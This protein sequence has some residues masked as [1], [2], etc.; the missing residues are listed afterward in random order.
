M[1]LISL[2]IKKHVWGLNHLNYSLTAIGLLIQTPTYIR[3]PTDR[4]VKWMKMAEQDFGMHGASTD[5][6]D[7]D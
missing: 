1:G 3:S 7:F 4:T 6:A 5:T 2:I